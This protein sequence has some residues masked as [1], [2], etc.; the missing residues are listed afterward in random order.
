MFCIIFKN[1]H[2]K[3]CDNIIYDTYEL[4]LTVLLVVTFKPLLNITFSFLYPTRSHYI[5]AF[6]CLLLFNILKSLKIPRYTQH[7]RLIYNLLLTEWWTAT[8]NSL[9]VLHKS[10]SAVSKSIRQ[11]QDRVMSPILLYSSVDLLLTSREFTKRASGCDLIVHDLSQLVIMILRIAKL[12]SAARLKT[13]FDG[14]L[15]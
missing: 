4:S 13:F 1:S 7:Y 9:H 8:N 3:R 2:V 5:H 12:F 10:K 11:C 14:S 15:L 6:K